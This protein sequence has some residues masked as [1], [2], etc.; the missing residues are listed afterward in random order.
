MEVYLYL[1]PSL[2]LVYLISIS[3]VG[4]SVLLVEFLINRCGQANAV[5][6]FKKIAPIS[7]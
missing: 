7:K 4:I 5:H 2:I 6:S 1:G 3:L